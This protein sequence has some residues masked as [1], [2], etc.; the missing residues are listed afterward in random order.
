[1]SHVNGF[2]ASNYTDNPLFNEVDIEDDD[3]IETALAIYYMYKKA[4]WG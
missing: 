4:G 3:D 1:M 2:E